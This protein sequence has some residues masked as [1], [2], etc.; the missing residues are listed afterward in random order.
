M[1]RTLDI[2]S[3]R[4]ALVG[5]LVAIAASVLAFAAI[6]GVEGA[7]ERNS[8]EGRPGPVSHTG[9]TV[10]IEGPSV[11]ALNENATIGTF[12]ATYTAVSS[13]N[14]AQ[15]SDPFEYILQG[16][17][18]DKYRIDP[19]SG[20]LRTAQWVDYE[21]DDNDM[22]TVLAFR[23]D[24][25]ATLDVT[26]NVQ[27]VDDSV[28]TMSVSKA[29]PVPGIHQG[30]P[31]H[32][33]DSN[34]NEF[35]ETE[36]ANWE[37]ILRIVVTSESPDPDCGTRQDCVMLA[38]LAHDSGD[39]QDITAVRSGAQGIR[40][41]AA[42][43]LVESEAGSGETI[44]IIGA[45][46]LSRS[47]ELL[48][49]GD[50]DEVSIAFG[51]LRRTVDVENVPP[52][53]D[54]FEPE[55]GSTLDDEDVDFEFRVVD[56]F[57]GLPEPEDLPDTDGDGK[58]MPVAALVHDSQCHNSPQSGDYLV[59]V[60]NLRLSD[61]AIYCNEQPEVRMIV[62]DKDF[63]EI[64]NGFEVDTTIVLPEGETSY[65]T[66]IACDN[67]GNCVAY[68]AD[69]DSDI[70]LL[71]VSI[72]PPPPVAPVDPCLVHITGDIAIDGVWD[73]SCPS[74][75]PPEPDGGIGDRYARYYTFTLGE[76]SDVTITLTSEED[77]YLYLLE[78]HG[79]G[80]RDL[81]ENDDVVQYIDF[82]SRIEE[83]LQPGDYTIEATTYYSGST[84]D[85][86]LVV[87]GISQ[88]QPEADCSSGYA[89]TD[90]DANPGLV[91]DCAALLAARDRLAGKT[92]LNWAADLPIDEWQGIT[93]RGSPPRV[94]D[95]ILSGYE[96]GEMSA[97]LGNLSALQAL[98]LSDNKLAGEIPPEL[99]NLKD[100]EV[101]S[102]WSNQLSGEI[103][104]E[105]G[106]LVNLWG[107]Y[108]EDNRLTGEIPPGLTDLVNLE[109]L[110][111]S[112]NDLVGCIPDGLRDVENND[113]GELG[114]SFCG[115]TVVPTPTPPA[116]P[117]ISSIGDFESRLEIIDN[118][119]DDDCGSV[120]RPDYGDTYARFFTFNLTVE[121]DVT[122]TLESDE[123]A[124]LYLLEGEGEGGTVLHEDDDSDGT[125]PRIQTTLKPGRYTVEATTY[126]IRV[127]GDFRIGVETD[128]LYGRPP[129]T[130][131]D[132]LESIESQVAIGIGFDLRDS[133]ESVSR[134]EDG[135]YNAS[136]MALTVKFPSHVTITLTSEEDAYLY[137]LEGYGVTGDILYEDDD[138]DGTNSR[139]EATLRPGVYTIE[140]TTYEKGI[141]GYF[142]VEVGLVSTSH[143]LCATGAAVPDLDNNLALLND[144]SLLLDAKYSLSAEPPLNWSADLPMEEWEGVFLGGLPLRVTGLELGERH[145]EGEIP[146][147]LR[148]L[149]GL[150]VL[151][152]DDNNL[153]GKIPPELGD[154]GSLSAL[155]LS[156]NRL[157]GEIPSELGKLKSLDKMHLSDNKLVGEIPAEL[158]ELPNLYGLWVSGN[159][160]S[161][162]I[163]DG[164]RDVEENDFDKLGL[165]FC[166][167]PPEP[168]SCIQ[169]LPS[170]SAI[171]IEYT[172]NAECR[173][174]RSPFKGTHYARWYTFRLNVPTLVNIELASQHLAYLYLLQ[175]ENE[176]GTALH[177]KDSY[178]GVARI[179]STLQPGIYTIETTTSGD[180]LNG[181]FT[182]SLSVLPDP[183][184]LCSKGVAVPAPDVNRGLVQD[185]AALLE[186]SYNFAAEP[187]LNWSADVPV[188]SW[189]GV[190]VDESSGRVTELALP[191]RG[192]EG[193]FPA[194]LGNL[195]RLRLLNLG[196][197]SFTG[198]IPAELGRLNRLQS[199]ILEENR[200]HGTLPVELAEL[201]S[202]RE[203]RISFNNIGGEIPAFLADLVNL[204]DLSIAS[205]SLT[206]EIPP[207]LGRLTNLRVIWLAG[208]GLTGRIPPEL[209]NL[210]NLEVLDLASNGLTGEIPPELGDLSN[211]QRLGLGRNAF[212]GEIPLELTSLTNLKDLYLYD[213]NLTGKIPTELTRLP[214]LKDIWLSNNQL[215]GEIP[216][217]LGSIVNLKAL[218]LRRNQLHGEIPPQLGNLSLLER[219]DLGINQLH[220]GIPTELGNL[221]NLTELLLDRNDLTGKIPSALGKLSDLEELFLY[222]NSL[223]GAIPSEIG[224]LKMLE[225]L[226]F[227][228]N[229]FNGEIPPELGELEYVEEIDLSHNQ[230]M[231]GIPPELGGLENLDEMDLSHNQ[232]TGEIPPELADLP[233]I[234]YINLAMNNLSGCI[235]YELRYVVEAD[236]NLTI[237][238]P[239]PLSHSLRGPLFVGGPDLE[240]TYI[241]RLPRY[242]KYKI[243]YF[244]GGDCGYPY[245]EFLGAVVC[246]EQDGIKRWPDVGET[247]QLIAHVWNFGDAASGPFDYHWSIDGATVETGR[248]NGL[249]PGE[250]AVMV[251]ER[252]WPGSQGNPTVTF[253]L[254]PNNSV[255]ELLE[256]NNELTDW[257]KGYTIGFFLS[258]V[259]YESLTHSNEP[260]RVMQSPE[261]WI[262]RNIYRLNEM[263][264]EAGVEDRVRTELFVITEDRHYQNS[265]Q[266][267]HYMDGWWSIL[268]N[269]DHFT[270]FNKDAYE[271][272]PE[273]DYGLL[274]E[275][276]HQLG[277]IDLYQMDL[278]TEGVLLPDANRP[279]EKAGCGTD[280]W[281]AVWECY[282]FTENGIGDLM[283]YLNHW[284]GPHT[285]GGLRS[286][287][288][289]RRGF[290]GEYL[291]DTPQITSI[292]IVDDDGNPLPN[293]ELRFYQ[294]E[295]QPEAGYI[296]DSTP[297]FELTTNA[298]GV[299]ALPNRGITGIVTATGHQLQPNPFGVIDVVGRNGIFIIEMEGALCTNYEWLTVVDLN[300]AYWEGHEE[301][302][303]FDRT[304]SCP[305]ATV[306]GVPDGETDVSAST[307]AQPV[308]E[309]PRLRL[310]PSYI[311]PGLDAPD[312]DA[313]SP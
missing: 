116:S 58:Y 162:C 192:I 113:F 159:N 156:G 133:C 214:D 115:D 3:P 86:M 102:L 5:L 88:A 39:E 199:L 226:N 26:V 233:S 221:S 266:L 137:L 100:L 166:S 257:M 19:N 68:D 63:D 218:R 155:V 196:R 74:G 114:L 189:E 186:A 230:L 185:C 181:D 50:E 21:T 219:L 134:S 207:E 293:T 138:T 169:P 209:G 298:T 33:L 109:S 47:V 288:G 149:S 301:K 289:H 254:D 54:Y 202:L 82:N 38:L 112:G 12:L 118:Q 124:Y 205:N 263:L 261:H 62:N 262:H 55:H 283:A 163:P 176:D 217:E 97:E 294:K 223:I 238:D 175:G 13:D 64:D 117:C 184:A 119:W 131:V 105:L 174:Q 157:S 295:E 96:L 197:N 85:F 274:H 130:C 299:A 312:S 231:G 79:T 179:V 304:L 282:R 194:E 237:C 76:T 66:F 311:P 27:D 272:R 51:D 281:N 70:V 10:S 139:I 101:L 239:P 228:E 84:G 93:T 147:W 150:E 129:I 170:V 247:V 81:F 73:G 212:T 154:M 43:K 146:F 271:H 158:A 296:V 9:D 71:Q 240:V 106:R 249:E 232:L 248:F 225:E 264:A 52:E 37:T 270:F 252:R 255:D 83:T 307:V 164:L 302:A 201:E 187:Q 20:E 32:A 136:Y 29:N 275:L 142:E 111:L 188:S 67:A 260:G 121:A 14:S 171:T 227:S 4:V 216:S 22:F 77:T 229:E 180:G 203:L 190:T 222:D 200:F 69:E 269:D 23:G 145:L 11:L 273:I 148:G 72:L 44:G 135:G 28:S 143:E 183:I 103:P 277:V 280:Y 290:Y 128:A 268:H 94:A 291:Y 208:N 60:E 168:E 53:F 31:E 210:S 16:K 242:E 42:V 89:V 127:T 297:E 75:R 78:G 243:A 310:P 59:A 87:E 285:A 35:V 256:D 303:V 61:G 161:G 306:A 6:Q 167:D 34:P 278:G 30:N 173:S 241:E 300:L 178:S 7:G 211:L 172:W 251:L 193:V 91:S 286:N 46:G 126:E 57:S 253:T 151:Y 284:I 246:P 17:D 204:E 110:Y 36:W 198:K 90:P 153:S 267:R 259:A 258:P 40:Y 18:A 95:L 120:N 49:V 15:S 25:R 24:E 48:Q 8:F 45:D 213:N 65:V 313:D 107:L 2:T 99:G 220:G 195:P 191:E 287:A 279:G 80:G 104:A 41:V 1:S 108:L 224:N 165:D 234:D 160:L 245:D 144:C 309:G 177:E 276:M 250:R 235:P 152:L 98:L 92:S 215:T 56:E 236:P 308:S 206:G 182:L 292:R 265:H 141:T 125:N 140:S 305:P 132:P 123:D 122:I 244:H